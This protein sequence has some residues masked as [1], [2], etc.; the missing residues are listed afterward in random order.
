MNELMLHPGLILW[1]VGIVAMLAPKAIRKYVLALGPLAAVGAAL[2]LPLGT[3]Y[4]MHFVRDIQLHLMYVDKLAWIFAFIFSVLALVSGIYAAHNPNR[5]EALC[6]MAYAG[7]AICVCLA[8]DWLSFIFFW[9]SLA[10]TSLFL[11]WC[12]PTH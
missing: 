9:E 4:T 8:K 1:V 3:E 2:K 10:V 6:S 12:N 7:G 5:M 11:V